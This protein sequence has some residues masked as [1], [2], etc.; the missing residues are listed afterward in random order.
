VLRDG[1]TF[2]L[3]RSLGGIVVA[4]AIKNYLAPG[5]AVVVHD[6]LF[7]QDV[8]DDV[9]L[10]HVGRQQWIALSKDDA[11]IRKN[12]PALVAILSCRVKIFVLTKQ[13]M[14]GGHMASLFVS[15]LPQMRKIVD[16]YPGPF[17]VQIEED[18]HMRGPLTEKRIVKMLWDKHRIRF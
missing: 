15:A 2:F 13:D 14:K 17:I 6:E 12:P 16:K 9:W 8:E 5:E 7:E 1:R 18:G 3:D 11:I 10:E 4:D